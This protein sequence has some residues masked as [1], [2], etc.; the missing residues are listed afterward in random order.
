MKRTFFVVIGFVW[1]SATGLARQDSSFVPGHSYFGRNQYIE[2]IAGNSPYV[3]SAPHG[4]TL[5]PSEIPDRT[6]GETVRD[7]NT[8][9]LA[10]TIGAAVFAHEGVYP[11]IIIC[12]LRRTKLDANRDLSEATEGGNQYAVQ[13]WKEFQSF[14]DTAE[15]A[16]N[17][18]FGKGFY[19]DLHGHGHVI[20]QLELGYILSRSTLGLSD[21]TLDNNTYYANSSSIRSL[22]PLSGISFS[23]LLR[24]PNSLGTLFE[25]QGFPATPSGPRPS[26]SNSD[27]FSGGYNTERHGSLG[28]GPVSGVQIEC[29]MTGVRENAESWSKF[30]TAFAEVIQ[31]YTDLHIF[32]KPA[33]AVRDESPLP[34]RFALLQNYPNPF[35][36]TTTISYQL[37]AN[38]FVTLEVFDVL[39]RK[40]TTLVDATRTPGAHLVRWDG[41]GFSSGVY[42]YRLQARDVVTG[43]ERLVETKKMLLIR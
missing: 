39:G 15:Q 9:T 33:T 31:Y 37:I 34:E 30:S 5:T 24:G 43:S 20:Q 35:N 2:Y 16:V 4:G 42:F 11:H 6:S 27:Y 29:N 13:A 22:V 28:G 38:S 36:P 12:H 26:P 21:N 41:S 10:K 17:R 3:V 19:V 32:H 18:D 23:K 14:I 8:D 1:A 40:V 7:T 25:N